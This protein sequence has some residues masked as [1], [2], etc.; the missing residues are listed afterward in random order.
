MTGS[1]R[2]VSSRSQQ[3]LLCGETLNLTR[4]NRKGSDSSSLAA[5]HGLFVPPEAA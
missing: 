2:R 4:K 3:G 1:V 5:V